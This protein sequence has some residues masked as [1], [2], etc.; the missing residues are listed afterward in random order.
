[1]WARSRMRARW[2]QPRE[3]ARSR[4]RVQPRVRVRVQ[5]W[6]RVRLRPRVRPRAQARFR[7][8]VGS[9]AQVRPRAQ[10]RS[11]A[12][13]ETWV[14]RARPR[15]L[16]R[17]RAARGRAERA[18]SRSP[19]RARARRR[20]WPGHRSGRPDPATRPLPRYRRGRL[21]R[22]CRRSR[23]APSPLVSVKP[24]EPGLIP[25]RRPLFRG[26]PTVSGRHCA[27]VRTP[28][29]PRRWSPRRY[30]GWPRDSCSGNRGPSADWP[31]A[32]RSAAAC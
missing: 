23:L 22:C 6:P 26:P 32:R 7:P 13:A 29:C 18:G 28:G 25:S 15:L 17:V 20:R 5:S 4:R 8:Q 11:R 31:G 1:M 19:A 10:V 3:S 27:P 2:A 12:R 14:Q 9:R 16:A 21:L 30:P 24:A